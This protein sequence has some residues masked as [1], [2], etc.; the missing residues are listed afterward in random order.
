MNKC[1]DAWSWRGRAEATCSAVPAVDTRTQLR[2]VKASASRDPLLQACCGRALGACCRVFAQTMRMLLAA[3]GTILLA[4]MLFLLLAVLFGS[5]QEIA[6]L[7]DAVHEAAEGPL[8]TPYMSHDCVARILDV[9]SASDVA[10]ERLDASL[11][12]SGQPLPAHWQDARDAATHALSTLK[13]A[14]LHCLLWHHVPAAAPMIVPA[15]PA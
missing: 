4:C 7:R 14:L 1:R 2:A 6:A 3:G 5:S 10:R 13:G 9:V 8:K 11:S 12:A 15:E